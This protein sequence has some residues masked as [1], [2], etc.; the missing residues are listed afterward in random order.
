MGLEYPGGARLAGLADSQTQSRYSLPK[1]SRE[2]ADL[3]F[4]GL[5]TAVSL[6]VERERTNWEGEP[7]L[8]AELAWAVQDAIVSALL[9]KVRHAMTSHPY[10]RDLHVVGGVSANNGLR[11]G[12]GSIPG[13]RV[14]LPQRAYCT[15]N[16][17]MIA[18]TAAVRH[19][20]GATPLKCEVRS[21]WPLEELAL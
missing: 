10:V 6:L 14:H 15:D 16:G 1:V 8:K 21:R 7:V 19:S 17:A 13:L 5:K 12:A 9:T 3:S 4:S 11:L 18:L 2:I 20:S